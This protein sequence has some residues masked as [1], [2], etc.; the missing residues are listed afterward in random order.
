MTPLIGYAQDFPII[1]DKNHRASISLT[2]YS[3]DLNSVDAGYGYKLI[4][5]NN[6]VITTGLT[7]GIFY[8]RIKLSEITKEDILPFVAPNVECSFGSKH[9]FYI[10]F[11]KNFMENNQAPFKSALGY[12]HI[13]V[14]RQMSLK[15]FG[16]F[17]W[18]KDESQLESPTVFTY[19]G[20]GVGLERN[21]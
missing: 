14:N 12:R 11:W 5:K 10:S 9:V 16:S 15:A 3:N 7:G 1:P 17:L 8:P 13:F 18:I 4:V 20:I 21:F 19:G 6:L 2:G